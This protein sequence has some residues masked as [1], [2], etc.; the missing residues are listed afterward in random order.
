[1]KRSVWLFVVLVLGT[2]LLVL[3][4]GVLS[5]RATVTDWAGSESGAH[6][7]QSGRLF[8]FTP[9]P[10]TFSSEDALSPDDIAAADF[11]FSKTVMLQSAYDAT[12][13]CAG[14]VDTLV[15]N[16]GTKVV[17]CYRFKNIG[18]TTFLTITMVDDKLGSLG[19]L[20]FTPPFVP[21]ASGGFLAYGV[22]MTQT[23]TNNATMTLQDDQG[24][25]VVKNDSA[26]VNVIIPTVGG[27]VFLDLNGDGFRQVE[28]DTGIKN[29]PVTLSN[30]AGVIDRKF[31]IESGWYQFL[32]VIPG[33]Y[34]LRIEVPDGYT[35]TSPIERSL[36][37][38]AG[39]NPVVDFG[40]QILPTPTPTATPTATATP[41]ITP[42]P[43]PSPTPTQT[44]TPT[45]SATPTSSPTPTPTTVL[46]LPP[47]GVWAQEGEGFV[48][49]FWDRVPDADAYL[50]WRAMTSG[51][52]YEQI[53][54]VTT[55]SH[56]DGGLE[57]GRVYYYVV[58]TLR[59][60]VRSLYSTEVAAIPHWKLSGLLLNGPA[61][62]DHVLNDGQPTLPLPA[63]V[64]VKHETIKPGPISGILME[65]GYGL[66]GTRPGTWDTWQP[67]AYTRDY[68]ISDDN[69]KEWEEWTG[70]LYPD[71]PGVYRV[72][73]RASATG[74]RDWLYAGLRIGVRHGGLLRVSP[75]VGAMAASMPADPS[76]GITRWVTVDTDNGLVDTTWG[77]PFHGG[78][79]NDEALDDRWE[80]KNAWVRNDGTAIYFR[81]E[82]CAGPA[83]G[84]NANLRVSGAIDCNLDGDFTDGF[85]T[86]PQGDRIVNYNPATD[87]DT[88]VIVSGS[89]QSV[90][91]Y[92]DA[93][94]ER[95]DDM[96]ME[97]KADLKDFYPMCRG[98][99]ERID[100][101]LAIIDVNMADAVDLTSVQPYRIPMD[102][103]D[104]P[105]N[106]GFGDCTGYKTRLKCD[107]PRHGLGGNLRL[108]AGVDPD[109]GDLQGPNA[110]A[111]D[112]TGAV[113]D[114][115]DGVTPAFGVRWRAGD[116]ALLRVLVSGGDGYLSCWFDWN[117][118]EDFADLGEMI[119]AN[120]AVS[121]GT[122]SLLFD[123]PS[124]VAFPRSLNA[125]CRL[126]P[127]PAL[128]LSPYGPAEFGEVEDHRWSFDADG[129]PLLGQHVVWLPVLYK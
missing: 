103:G 98:S 41:T 125:R 12:Q 11:R 118:D 23:I 70:V 8:S 108:G 32:D 101:A 120:T 78:A 16:Y 25:T 61:I 9:L 64:R 79:C 17:Y 24:N 48:V 40:L 105:D 2:V 55:T 110:D 71:Q 1:M 15:V 72:L 112:L 116:T 53:A 39:E 29:V 14:S 102:Y 57:N 45:P 47:T 33:T 96:N 5:S 124:D 80:I 65:V 10:T 83:L 107:G 36:E 26:T 22:P 122:Q 44:L 28:E 58:Q 18:T 81:L 77:E 37:V 67:M 59:G 90:A 127:E 6:D 82:T 27:Y 66:E 13:S 7:L 4:A 92:S 104:L 20:A 34:T 3:G 42:T 63:R 121:V 76:E 97:W 123:V 113:P 74:G 21:N 60:S 109:G 86:G 115:E 106:D 69:L 35:P 46:P 84:G 95:P 31:S 100:L 51:G 88:V 73:V 126:S 68:P 56:R 89:G 99:A 111:D 50:V 85:E 54:Q 93:Y 129:L 38:V 62:L 49:L 19:P 128:S 119:L 87:P 117:E 52:P 75:A 94:G 114:D 43:T 91:F 30:S